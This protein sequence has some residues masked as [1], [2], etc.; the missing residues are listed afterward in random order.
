MLI[1]S[2]RSGEQSFNNAEDHLGNL[3]I[4]SNTLKIWPN[5][6]NGYDDEFG[7]PG[8]KIGQTLNVRKPQRFVGRQGSLFQPEASQQSRHSGD[9]QPADRRRLPVPRLR[10]VSELG[11]VL[12][13]VPAAG[14]RPHR[15][16]AGLCGGSVHGAVHM[17]PRPEPTGRLPPARRRST[18]TSKHPRSSGRTWPIRKT[19]AWC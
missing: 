13:A 19:A 3:A 11:S 18:L 12:E 8:E 7:R 5:L 10:E 15:Q 14:R 4:L 17:E 6:Y 2:A 16:H 1:R 9:D